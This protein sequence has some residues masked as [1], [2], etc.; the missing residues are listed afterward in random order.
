MPPVPRPGAPAVRLSS[1]SMRLPIPGLRPAVAAAAAIVVAA[2]SASVRA[3]EAS[4]EPASSAL[5][6]EVIGECPDRAELS[7]A[8]R[9][10]VRVGG[11]RRL[12]VV[13]HG[14]G[15]VVLT[16]APDHSADDPG[17]RRTF[18][19]AD[20]P[21]A[22]GVVA[23]IVERHFL[24]LGRP[25]SSDP[26]VSSVAS[27]ATRLP[28]VPADDDTAPP[29]GFER[30]T[31]GEPDY[32]RPSTSAGAGSAPGLSVGLGGGARLDLGPSAFRG[33]VVADI[34]LRFPSRLVLRWTGRWGTPWT[35]EDQAERLRVRQ[36]EGTI[37]VGAELDLGARGFMRLAGGTG[38]SLARVVATS[39]PDR[40]SVLRPIWILEAAV[41][42][43]LWL[44]PT[45]ALRLNLTGQVA[46][47]T[48]RY[49]VDPS[50]AVGESPRGSVL[51]VGA[52]EWSP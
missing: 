28:V 25:P 11:T 33:A 49:I 43:G 42:V 39:L 52:V 5:A 6:L 34:T 20:C 32:A 51:L 17:L 1:D 10:R 12:R 37:A 29:D 48:D 2:G 38:G 22:A 4:S 9:S 30:P 47:I 24:V 46:P 41:E 35:I 50:G 14:G 13:S 7:S 31:P 23:V 40:P 18:V 3:Q 8:L 21:A 45:W 16:L 15:R 27:A 26:L 44:R 19:A 36:G